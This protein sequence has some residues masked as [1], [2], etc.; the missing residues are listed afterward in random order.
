MQGERNDLLRKRAYDQGRLLD[1]QMKVEIEN[2]NTLI[3]K[4]AELE[5]KKQQQ[6]KLQELEEAAGENNLKIRK[7]EIDLM[8]GITKVTANYTETT[9]G[10]SVE[11]AKQLKAEL[12]GAALTGQSAEQSMASVVRA[13]AMEAVAGLISSIFKTIPY[14]L[15]LILAAGAGAVASQAI[16]RNMAVAKRIKLADGGIVPGVGNQDTVPAMLTPGELILNQS[17]LINLL[18]IF[19]SLQ[20]L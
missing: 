6:I 18:R 16:D 10:L 9:K 5:E 4:L 20:I 3:R 1:E 12:R 17:H 8:D 14:P 11:K 13:E 19:L 15:N 2:V 7:Q